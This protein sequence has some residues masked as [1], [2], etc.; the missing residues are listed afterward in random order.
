MQSASRACLG[1]GPGLRHGWGTRPSARCSVRL[2]IKCESEKEFRVAA[3][4]GSQYKFCFVSLHNDS[5]NFALLSL[6]ELEP[7][8][9]TKRTQFQINLASLPRSTA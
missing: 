6:S 9:K 2:P 5:R 7:L 3:K 8:I 1:R 4:L